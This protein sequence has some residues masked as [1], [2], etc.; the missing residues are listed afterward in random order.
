[1]VVQALSAPAEPGDLGAAVATLMGPQGPLARLD[2]DYRER[3]EQSA[4]AQAVASA[5]EGHQSLV[6]EAGT[7]VGKT[8]AYLIPLLLSGR[9]GLVSTATKS[10]QDQLYWRDLPRLGERAAGDLSAL[11]GAAERTGAVLLVP[12]VVDQVAAGGFVDH[13]L[14]AEVEEALGHLVD[15]DVDDLGHVDLRELLED[16][17]VREAVEELR[18]KGPLGL[19]HDAVLQLL[20]PVVVVV[21]HL[22]GVGEVVVDLAALLPEV[23]IGVTPERFAAVANRVLAPKILPKLSTEH[24]HMAM[25]SVAVESR[26]VIALLQEPVF[27]KPGSMVI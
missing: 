4:M 17:D 14:H 12:A 25:V 9:R 20:E 6:V 15:L 21:Q 18:L 23:M 19:V 2:A 7:G 11:D 3:A 22:L 1:M 16:D 24:L 8:Y 27:P 5:I 26:N 10:L 13:E